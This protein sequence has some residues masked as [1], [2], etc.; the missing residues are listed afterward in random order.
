MRERFIRCIMQTSDGR[1]VYGITV[2]EHIAVKLSGVPFVL[3]RAGSDII[4]KAIQ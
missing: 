1:K 4:C 3:Y 2:D